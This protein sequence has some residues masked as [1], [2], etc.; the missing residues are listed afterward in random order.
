MIFK[1]ELSWF[2]Y[3]FDVVLCS[4]NK[5]NKMW[6]FFNLIV[7]K[8]RRTLIF[9]SVGLSCGRASTVQS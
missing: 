1:K 6:F 5:L 2:R 4:D 3:V 7:K 8:P 9:K